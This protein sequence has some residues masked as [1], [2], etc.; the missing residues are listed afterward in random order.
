MILNLSPES[1]T[2]VCDRLLN[3]LA[4]VQA[5]AAALARDETVDVAAIER[6]AESA[7]RLLGRYEDDVRDLFNLWG[8]KN[9]Y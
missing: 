1:K 9:D 7:T 5:W 6:C 3:D 2:I 8:K 4:L